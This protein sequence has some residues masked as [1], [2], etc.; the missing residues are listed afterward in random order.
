VT[1]APGGATDVVIRDATIGDVERELARLRAASAADGASSS[2]RT[3]VAT[4]IA[5]VPERWVDAATR[6]LAGLEERHPSRTILLFPR[7]DSPRDALDADVDLRC[8]A[9]GGSRGAVCFEV[10]EIHLLGSRASAPASVVTPLLVSDL[11]VFLRWRGDLPFGEPELEELTALTD[12]LIVDSTEW[13]AP[14]G[15]LVRLPELF[16]RTAVSDIAWARTQP[17]RVALADLWPQIADVSTLRVAGPHAEALLL[18][19]WLRS[20]LQRDVEL[21]HEPA[22]ELEL[23]EADGAAAE[24]QHAAA[25]SASDLLSDQLELFSRERVYEEAVRSFSQVPI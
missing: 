20:R 18:V 19:G 12:R 16:E 17:W 11:P 22:G 21:E 10:V 3:S 4:H 2:L 25:K 6:T 8:F 23:V 24:L 1:A 9:A 5:W 13:S 14:E 15:G 7:P